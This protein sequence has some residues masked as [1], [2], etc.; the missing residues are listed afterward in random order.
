[1]CRISQIERYDIKKALG[2]PWITRRFD[3]QVPRTAKEERVAQELKDVLG[4]GM[5]FVHSL[6]TL[7]SSIN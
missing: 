3:D 6:V 1:M 7:S 2:H 4:R 5:R